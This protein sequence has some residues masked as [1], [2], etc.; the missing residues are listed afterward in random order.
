MTPVRPSKDARPT[1]WRSS[2]TARPPRS[3]TSWSVTPSPARITRTTTPQSSSGVTSATSRA[4]RARRTPR[5]PQERPPSSALSAKVT[6]SSNTSSEYMHTQHGYHQLLA[7]RLTRAATSTGLWDSA[8]QYYE[9]AKYVARLRARKTDNQP[10]LLDADW[11]WGHGGAS[12]RFGPLQRQARQYA[13]LLDLAGV[14]ALNS[15]AS[16]PAASR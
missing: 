12:G 8:V 10:L 7:A 6:T 11:L 2:W 4:S 16:V 1:T 3:P 15:S 13:F 5:R 9:P 14:V